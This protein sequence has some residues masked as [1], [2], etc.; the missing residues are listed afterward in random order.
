MPLLAYAATAPERQ[1]QGLGSCVIENA[2]RRLN[3]LGVT[4]FHLAV[5]P[6]SPARRLYERL[7]FE[8]VAGR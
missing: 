3:A 6:G 4:E 7:G 5:L 8:L 2:V 1:G